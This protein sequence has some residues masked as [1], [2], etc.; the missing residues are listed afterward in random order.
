VCPYLRGF[1]I[2]RTRRNLF[3]LIAFLQF[4]LFGRVLSRTY[5]PEPCVFVGAIRWT[6]AQFFFPKGMGRECFQLEGGSLSPNSLFFG[7]ASR[8]AI[9]V[10]SCFTGLM[11]FQSFLL[12]FF[13]MATV[14]P[15][16]RDGGV[17]FGTNS[18]NSFFVLPAF[19]G[20]F[21][22]EVGIVF[23]VLLPPR[24]VVLMTTSRSA[25]GASFS[26]FVQECVFSVRPLSSHSAPRCF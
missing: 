14:A 26:F 3:F 21:Y 6:S 17:V 18:L 25:P 12:S 1:L 19:R 15:A 13:L 24:P 9:A 10:S 2:P 7:S 8:T 20:A 5:I 23:L 16:A 4:F 22:I 11:V